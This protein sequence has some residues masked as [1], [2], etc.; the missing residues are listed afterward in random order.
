[1]GRVAGAGMLSIG[2]AS[3]VARRDAQPPAIGVLAAVLTYNAAS[4]AV[5]ILAG[6]LAGTVGVLLWPAVGYHLALTAWSG[7]SVVAT[8]RSAA[9]LTA[10]WDRWH[11]GTPSSAASPQRSPGK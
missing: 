9:D 5:L 4:A 1:M 6:A 8:S 10:S 7:I 3:W 11:S 2:V